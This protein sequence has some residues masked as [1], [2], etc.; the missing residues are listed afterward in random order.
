MFIIPVPLVVT[1][2]VFPATN[3]LPRK[4]LSTSL[5]EHEDLSFSSIEGLSLQWHSFV[6]KIFTEKILVYHL[7]KYSLA[8]DLTLYACSLLTC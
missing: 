2:T 5:T 4:I 1:F 6:Q 3:C 8:A 7:I